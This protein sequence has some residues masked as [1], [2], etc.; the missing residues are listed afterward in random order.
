MYFSDLTNREIIELIEEEDDRAFS[1]GLGPMHRCAEIKYAL[2]KR[3]GFTNHIGYAP[4]GSASKII[5]DYYH[6]M[7]RIKDTSIDAI[8]SGIF[9]HKDVFGKIYLPVFFGTN[10]IDYLEF[11]NLNQ[12]QKIY[13][14]SNPTDHAAYKECCKDIFQ[15][16]TSIFQSDVK[17]RL[18][19]HSYHRF[20]QA[21]LHLQSATAILDGGSSFRGAN[22]SSI[23]AVE[24][25]LKAACIAA[26]MSDRQATDFK[27]RISEIYDALSDFYPK[28][29]SNELSELIE[30]TPNY[31]K[32]RYENKEPTRLYS[33]RNIMRAQ[34]IGSILTEEFIG[35]H[36]R[37][38]IIKEG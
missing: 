2:S 25:F 11:T 6:S 22:Q 4:E 26:G 8:H 13:I 20:R 17:R 38:H 5:D 9:M 32:D 3:F 18:G 16:G 7:Y 21:A 12:Y 28:I 15:I 31:V 29:R 14:K 19:E 24:Q 35:H 27:H 36:W 10:S 30:R 33:G 37:N 23:L 34:R 1:K